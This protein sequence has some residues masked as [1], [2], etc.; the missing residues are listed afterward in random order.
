MVTH[1]AW[2][3]TG[4]SLQS[5]HDNTHDDFEVVVVDNASSDGTTA[6]LSTIEGLVVISND[7]NR[8]FGPASNQGAAMAKGDYL[9]LLNSD[10]M[11]QAGWSDGLLRALNSHPDAV[12][13]APRLL[14]LDGSLQEAGC[15]LWSDGHTHVYGAKDNPDDAQ[16]LF[17][18]RV[19]YSSA[20]C[21]AVRR[22]DFLAV[23]GFDE[24]FAPAFF[25][26]ADL[27]YRL[28]SDTRSILYTPESSVVH[29]RGIVAEPATT[30]D[31]YHRNRVRF[32]QRW[33]DLL[34]TRPPRP[35]PDDSARYVGGRDW[36]CAARILLT[37][38]TSTLQPHVNTLLRHIATLWPTARTTL[39][40]PALRKTDIRELRREGIEV[41]PVADDWHSGLQRREHHYDAVISFEPNSRDHDNAL[42]MT[43][44][45]ARH[46]LVTEQSTPLPTHTRENCYTVVASFASTPT[47]IPANVSCQLTL[48]NGDD[49][50]SPLVEAFSHL[51]IAP[52]AAS[53]GARQQG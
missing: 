38:D 6:R 17:T 35:M 13:A 1:N 33:R 11:V 7:H 30:T 10:A 14:N 26:D 37:M 19:D 41:M 53:E 47:E 3:W 20:A 52:P 31:I 51:G 21:L 34:P 4:Q 40:S 2:Q 28:A 48:H 46:M 12:A 9:V 23:H 36:L 24:M 18:R 15:F 16:Y 27:C 49:W 25:E 42:W 45:H 29:V 43:Q 8:G 39:I 22:S 5:L 50:Q 32:M 44:P